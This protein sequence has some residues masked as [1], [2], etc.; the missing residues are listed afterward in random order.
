MSDINDLKEGSTVKCAFCKKETTI[1]F[2]SDYQGTTGYN[3]AC[4]HRNAMCP[5]CHQLAKD[6]SDKISEVQKH[7]VNCDPVIEDEDED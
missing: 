2:I 1:Q 5:T 7:C 4:F 6:V 3:L